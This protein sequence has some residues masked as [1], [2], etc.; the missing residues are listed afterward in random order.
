VAARLGIPCVCLQQGWS[1]VV[2]TGFRNMS[3]D[4]MAVWGAG[5]AEL[6]EPHNPDQEFVVTGSPAFDRRDGAGGD[7]AEQIGGRRTVGF[8]TGAVS[9]L[10]A[11]ADV[12]EFMALIPAVASTL[13]D[14]AVLV[15]E[16][17]AHPLSQARL[18]ELERLPNVLL[19]PPR[20]YPLRDVLLNSDV[21]VSDYS[22]TLIEGV[23]MQRPAVVCNQTSMPRYSPDVEAHGVGIEVKQ[24]AAARDAIARLVSDRAFYDEFTA[25]MP[26]FRN[27]FFAG[28][29]AGA[30]ARIVALLDELAG[31]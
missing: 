12:D 23:A 21:V 7:L 6:L 30:G 17:P 20:R 9:P 3:F 11:Q 16:H 28:A 31:P 10:L 1:P 19:A 27:R 5:F 4:R 26:A 22:T 25:R 13:P 24:T 8:F 18:A 14:A 2:H 29:D 15:R